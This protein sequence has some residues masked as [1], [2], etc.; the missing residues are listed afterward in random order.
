MCS[1][2][3]PSHPNVKKTD[4]VEVQASAQALSK[5]ILGSLNCILKFHDFRMNK[6][7][8]FLISLAK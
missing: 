4:K 8:T 2:R 5:D 7:S 1:C 6:F 3:I